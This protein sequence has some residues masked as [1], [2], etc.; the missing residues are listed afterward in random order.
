MGGRAGHRA[1]AG[2][3]AALP[4]AGPFRDLA[5]TALALARRFRGGGTLWC[6][7]PAW[8]WH[9][10]HVAVEFVHPVV[11]GTRALPAVSA[12]GPD[13][14]AALRV[15]AR[16]GDMVLA[17]GPAGDATVADVMR[18]APTWGLRTV[19]IG[20]GPRPGPGAADHVLWAGGDEGV[21]AFDGGLVL[22]YH[23]LWELVH[24]C[25]EHPGL[26]V[27]ETVPDAAAVCVT[28]ADQGTVAEVVALLSGNRASV[29]A[30][31]VL[32]EVDVTLVDVP[33]PGGLVLVHA[34]SAVAVVQDG[35][36]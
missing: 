3:E 13:V 35:A 19:W 5:T 16:P 14:V 30:G 31:G 2:A 27:E 21:T 22:V 4:D 7:S 8:P 12:E 32:E 17:L 28:C 1:G 10:R 11:V 29:R 25:L 18:R 24:V 34:G 6:V 33:A 23:V 36:P 15:G 20:A 26:L 9:A